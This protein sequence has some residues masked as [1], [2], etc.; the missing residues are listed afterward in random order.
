[1]T[2]TISLFILVIATMFSGCRNERYFG[3]FSLEVPTQ[4]KE[5]ASART[6]LFPLDEPDRNEIEDLAQCEI[7]EPEREVPCIC[8]YPILTV[9][10]IDIRL[11]YRLSHQSGESTSVMVWVGREVPAGEPPP[12]Y[13]PDLP[14]IE[15]L[16]EHHH[17]VQPAGIISSSFLEDEMIAVKLALATMLHP[18]CPQE[19]I[20]ALPLDLSILYGLSVAV[21]NAAVIAGEFS[22]RIQEND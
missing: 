6:F 11:D 20:G 1:M 3:P 18:N 8:D 9:D 21:D 14:R 15:V 7:D 10:E 19:D 13:F 4:L 17:Q 12:E 5:D 16:A 2:R 22:F